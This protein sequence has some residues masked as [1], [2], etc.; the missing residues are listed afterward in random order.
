MDLAFRE[1]MPNN[2]WVLVWTACPTWG[3]G[4]W[5]SEGLTLE[6]LVKDCRSTQKNSFSRRLH[7]GSLVGSYA[8]EWWS[9]RAEHWCMRHLNQHAQSTVNHASDVARLLELRFSTPNNHGTPG[10][11]CKAQP[12]GRLCKAQPPG[13]LDEFLRLNGPYES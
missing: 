11:L 10:R 9:H 6:C 13:A 2:C 1:F 3:Q 7:E 5:R 4:F 12:P 8:K